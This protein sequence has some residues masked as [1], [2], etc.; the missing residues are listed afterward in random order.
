MIGSGEVKEHT[1]W[2][3]LLVEGKIV[4]GDK[5]GDPQVAMRT[6]APYVQDMFVYAPDGD[7]LTDDLTEA[8]AQEIEKKLLAEFTGRDVNEF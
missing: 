7:L 6:L 1:E 3:G 5:E 4:Y 2:K 8:A